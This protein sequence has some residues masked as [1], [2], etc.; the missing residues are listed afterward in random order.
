MKQ[1]GVSLM[2]KRRL[3]FQNSEPIPSLL[4][5]QGENTFVLLT[6]CVVSLYI[7]LITD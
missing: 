2:P 3:V 7:R 4:L 5:I 6:L 1:D